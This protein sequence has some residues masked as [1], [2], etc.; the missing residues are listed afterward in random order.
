MLDRLAHRAQQGDSRA[1][2]HLCSELAPLLERY[3]ASGLRRR[4]DVEDARQQVLLRMLQALPRYRANGTPVRYWV[5]RIAQNYLRDCARSHGAC[6][7]H[8]PASLSD[9]LE[10]RQ[11]RDVPSTP[12]EQ[13]DSF[14]ELIAPLKPE[15]QRVLV[16]LFVYDLT[17]EQAG[18]VLAR[19]AASVRQLRKRGLDALRALVAQAASEQTL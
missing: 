2:A 9:E 11:V 10:L 5:I 19:T 7:S 16:L 17:P 12:G 18:M 13:R 15:Q 8:E 6:T 3:L 1:R 4:H 14:H